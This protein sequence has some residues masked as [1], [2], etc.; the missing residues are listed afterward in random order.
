MRKPCQINQRHHEMKTLLNWCTLKV[1]HLYVDIYRIKRDEKR[2][3][4]LQLFIE[5][6]NQTKNLWICVHGI[7]YVHTHFYILVASQIT[8]IWIRKKRMLFQNAILIWW[9]H[10]CRK[11]LLRVHN[12]WLKDF[13]FNL[14]EVS[15]LLFNVF[16]R[17]GLQ[18]CVFWPTH[19][20]YWTDS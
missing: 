4:M 9:M 3:W 5:K 18:E 1:C 8:S 11:D 15:L 14:Y 12:I 7:H 6:K 10:L 19:Y 13:G 17:T 20:G 2:H 16:F